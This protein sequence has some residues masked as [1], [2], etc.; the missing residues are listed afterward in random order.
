MV[1][2]GVFTDAEADAAFR[3]DKWECPECGTPCSKCEVLGRV[4]KENWRRN[5]NP[6]FWE[7]EAIKPLLIYL[8][9]ALPIF[10]ILMAILNWTSGK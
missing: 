3:W 6:H 2:E 9:I 10:F 7:W 5:A 1:K 8:I 4:E